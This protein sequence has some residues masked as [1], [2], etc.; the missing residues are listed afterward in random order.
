M[1][2][3]SIVYWDESPVITTLD[4]IAAPIQKVQFPTVTVCPEKHT[5][6]NN[7]AY[8]EKVLNAFAFECYDKYP[9]EYPDCSKTEALRKD[10]KGVLAKIIN[11]FKRNLMELEKSTFILAKMGTIIL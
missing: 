3:S 6:P 2:H 9:T 4:S 11:Y 1:I 7:W 10:F 8:V 5:P